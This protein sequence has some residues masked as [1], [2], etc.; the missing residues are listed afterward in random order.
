MSIVDAIEGAVEVA[1]ATAEQLAARIA[2]AGER[3]TSGPEEHPLEQQL[4]AASS[5]ADLAPSPD[6]I[7]G[8]Y[9]GAIRKPAHPVR[10]GGAIHA[11]M[12]GVHTTDMVPEDWPALVHGWQGR[13][14]DGSCCHFG[15]GRTEQDGLLQFV[16]ITRNAN[17]M[18]GPL[19]GVIDTAAATGLHPNTLVVGVEL[20]CAGGLHLVRGQWRFVEGGAAH[21]APIPASDVIPDP[22]RPGRGWHVVTDYQRA[23]LR[24]LR[25]AL[26]SQLEPLPAGARA[27]SRGERPPA[28]AVMPA[29]SRLVTHVE[30]DPTNRADPWRPT[31][32]WLAKDLAR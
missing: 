22:D 12:L 6:W 27:R 7:D 14:G 29:G 30:L 13:A 31:C 15:I 25:A 3:G 2:T 23:T 18:G 1:E 24:E 32:E 17:H 11:V 20:H 5:A 28:F 4:A 10:V 26:E 19:H 8:W 21:G 16:P 9:R